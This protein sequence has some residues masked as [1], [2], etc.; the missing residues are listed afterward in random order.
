MVHIMFSIFYVDEKSVFFLCGSTNK[1]NT[2]FYCLPLVT[3]TAVTTVT[4]TATATAAAAAVASAAAVA[5]LTALG[6]DYGSAT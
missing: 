2:C 1:K 6:I 4:L 5:G 3:A